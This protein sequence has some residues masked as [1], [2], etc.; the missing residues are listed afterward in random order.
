MEADARQRIVVPWA[1]QCHGTVEA[2]SK[3]KVNYPRKP[4][5]PPSWVREL[6][7]SSRSQDSLPRF[8]CR[9]VGRTEQA[10]EE[11]HFDSEAQSWEA[12]PAYNNSTIYMIGFDYRNRKAE[13]GGGGEY[14]GGGGPHGEATSSGGGGAVERL[15]SHGYKSQPPFIGRREAS[16]KGDKEE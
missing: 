9:K 6:S 13:R 16:G 10:E 5:S 8:R 3:E 7:V 14:E 15:A 1:W 12:R 11:E 4:S 2:T